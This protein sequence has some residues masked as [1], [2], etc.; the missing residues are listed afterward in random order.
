MNSF[1]DRLQYK[2]I[3]FII[4]I[5]QVNDTRHN[6]DST[7]KEDFK[8]LDLKE[9]D[10]KKEPGLCE[11]RQNSDQNIEDEN[12]FMY[13]VSTKVQMLND[14]KPPFNEFQST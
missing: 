4:Q 12:N 13:E 11:L 10:V 14:E 1:M 8:H 7:T 6:P 9:D 2:S 3:K 5:F